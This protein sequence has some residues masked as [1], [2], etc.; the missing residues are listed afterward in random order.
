MNAVTYQALAD[1]LDS[2]TA[3]ANTRMNRDIAKKKLEQEANQQQMNYDIAQRQLGVSQQNADTEANLRKDTGV[4]RQAEGKRLLEQQQA[5][6][7]PT[8][9]ENQLKLAQAQQ[10]QAQALAV[11][12]KPQAQE[13]GQFNFLRNSRNQAQAALLAAQQSGDPQAIASAQSDLDWVGKA[14]DKMLGKAGPQPIDLELPSADGLGK[15]KTQIQPD[16]WGPQHPLWQRFNDPT[17]GLKVAPKPAPAPAPGV[18]SRIGAVF[19]GGN[20]APTAAPTL[21]PQQQQALNWVKSNP[22]DPRAPKI[23]QQLGVQP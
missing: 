11:G 20:P 21:T 1:G 23:L 10:A 17:G 7:D 13:E 18:L 14:F 3:M 16:Q 15:I 12:Q 8:T 19:T 6:L 4:W 5:A 22:S 2:L 9:P